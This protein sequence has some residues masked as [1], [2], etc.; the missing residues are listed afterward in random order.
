MRPI[1]I[2]KLSDSNFVFS[3]EGNVALE[4]ILDTITEKLNIVEPPIQRRKSTFDND[5]NEI[6]QRKISQTT[7][8]ILKLEKNALQ[9]ILS[10]I[11]DIHCSKKVREHAE[12]YH[13]SEA[14]S[15][16]ALR[17]ILVTQLKTWQLKCVN[18]QHYPL[19]REI[20]H[21]IRMDFYGTVKQPDN[22]KLSTIYR[23]GD[24]DNTKDSTFKD[25]DLSQ[26][27]T[28][29]VFRQFRSFRLLEKTIIANLM[30]QG[31]AP[32]KAKFLNSYDFSDLLFKHFSK[33]RQPEG[34]ELHNVSIFLGARQRFVKKFIKNN[35]E[36]FRNYLKLSKVDD[37][38][39]ELLI[40]NMHTK[41]TTANIEVIDPVYNEEQ[42]K[43]LRSHNIIP[44]EI[45]IDDEITEEHIRS[46]RT[47]SL[48]YEI[49]T[50]TE[51]GELI[52]G[53]NFSVHHKVAV[54]D[55]GEK[56]NFSDVNLFRNLCLMVKP[57]HNIAHSLDKTI[58]NNNTET[59]VSRI[60]LDQDLAFYGG[61]NQIF[62]IYQ[63]FDDIYNS[64]N[65]EH[66]LLNFKNKDKILFSSEETNSKPKGSNRKDKKRQKI[67]EPRSKKALNGN[68]LERNS[69]PVAEKP[70]KP[71]SETTIIT[72]PQPRTLPNPQKIKQKLLPNRPQTIRRDKMDDQ[73]K[74]ELRAITEAQ[75]IKYFALRAAKKAA[76][77]AMRETAGLD[78]ARNQ[79]DA[80]QGLGNIINSIIQYK[81][82]QK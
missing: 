28:W 56:T 73:A 57:Y 60:E 21:I 71:S 70:I 3:N 61:L 23:Q 34:I 9:N 10:S 32:N 53:P 4:Q 49:L 62:Q 41:G 74:L 5:N 76:Q 27:P 77:S 59:Y 17:D 81:Q 54:Q 58:E 66:V 8:D 14:Q 19:P 45:K 15:R 6:Y 55:G 68:I 46:I 7:D 75:K 78:R 30:K 25:Y 65:D 31:I 44:Q 24:P 50:H 33:K 39:T 51:N 38:Y 26:S 48:M 72:K 35:E 80:K 42:I 29:M 1:R 64:H 2:D 43:I 63:H 37:R 22:K 40:R 82:N 13:L 69:R 16:E 12:R 47:A 67:S 11:D 79:A 20:K 36:A 18:K 52:T